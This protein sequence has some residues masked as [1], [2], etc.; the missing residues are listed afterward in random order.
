MLS[1]SKALSTR[2]LTLKLFVEMVSHLLSHFFRK[3]VINMSNYADEIPHLTKRLGY[4]GSVKKSWLITGLLLT[5]LMVIQ[6]L[7][8]IN[9]HHWTLT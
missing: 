9:S 4:P 8:T 7:I 6:D 5:N 3:H 1:A 2:S